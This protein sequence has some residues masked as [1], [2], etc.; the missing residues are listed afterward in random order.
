MANRTIT[1]DPAVDACYISLS[2]NPV[3]QT[4]EFSEDVLVDLDEYG[5][6]VGIEVLSMTATFPLT[7]LCSKL[8]IHSRDESFLA[9]LLPTLGHSLRF[10]VSSAPDPTVKARTASKQGAVFA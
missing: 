5:V 4:E 7:D 9:T 1:V 6:A 2:S 10:T 8:H 3:E